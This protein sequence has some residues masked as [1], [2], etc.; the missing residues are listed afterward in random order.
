M[1]YHRAGFDVVGVDIKPQPNYPFTF[2]Q[3]D[4]LKVLNDGG[5]VIAHPA[6]QWRPIPFLIAEFAA[7]HAS[8][9][10]QRWL[11][12]PGA[13]GS[14]EYPDLLTPT[15]EL[16][17]A[18]GL[19]YV[20]ENVPAALWHM[21]PPRRI[22][23]LVAE[24]SEDALRQMRD[25]AKA[26]IARLTVEVEIYEEALA[27]KTRKKRTGGGRLSRDQVHSIVWM[28]DKPLTAAEV[29]EEI[30]RQ[31][32]TVTLNAVRNHLNRLADDD[33]RLIRL[34]DG[35]FGMPVT[36]VQHDIP[37]YVDHDPEPVPT[38]PDEDEEEEYRRREE[39]ASMYDEEPPF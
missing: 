31:G 25:T 37:D 11:G 1:G 17:Q 8:P 35:R 24:Q 28:S 21:A 6:L 19:P 38:Q 10:C 33:H 32:L 14:D 22:V 18:T 4:A 36:R 26:E 29:Q 16:L 15:R 12:V 5:I 3:A 2:V 39:E 27:R 7:I 9:P 13:L 23:D 20:I 30:A 34:P